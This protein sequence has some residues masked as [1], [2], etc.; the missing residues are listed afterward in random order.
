MGVDIDLDIKRLSGKS[1]TATYAEI[2][3]Y[4]EKEHRLNVST[5]YIAQIMDKIGLERRMNYR[6]GSGEGKAPVCPPE[7]EEVIMDAFRHCNLI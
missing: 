7:K 1:G 2:K 3:A 5:L 4:V 6:N